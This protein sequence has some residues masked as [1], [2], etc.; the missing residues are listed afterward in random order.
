MSP[1][2][3]WGLVLVGG[4]TG[5]AIL[6]CA[7]VMIR[8]W[9]RLAMAMDQVPAP[10]RSAVGWPL[11]CAT[12]PPRLNLRR[13]LHLLALLGR[14]LL[15]GA[16]WRVAPAALRPTVRVFRFCAAALFLLPVI[17]S[18][19]AAGPFIAVAILGL[20]GVLARQARW[21]EAHT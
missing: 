19:L 9:N 8:A 18:A 4:L 17:G 12:I 7:A 13:G 2:A 1:D 11:W 16:P 5:L 6:A 20:I 14:V 3:P 21:A 10:D 15:Q